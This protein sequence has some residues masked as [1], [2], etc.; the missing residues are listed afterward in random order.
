MKVCLIE[1]AR[2]FARLAV[3]EAEP[4]QESN[5]S[6]T[7]VAKSEV[8]LDPRPDHLG[9]AR[10][11]S[12]D[13]VLQRSLLIFRQ[14]A[15]ATFMAEAAY[16]VQ[17]IALVSTIPPAHRVIVQQQCRCDFG[18]TPA[19]IEKNN[20]VR[21]PRDAMFGKPVTRQPYQRLPLC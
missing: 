6:R 7:A 3:V 2:G 11:P 14:A 8:L 5:Q 18:A 20:R 16:A 19:G 1:V 21:S 15:C 4:V 10:Q 9:A 13:P 17:A 12:R